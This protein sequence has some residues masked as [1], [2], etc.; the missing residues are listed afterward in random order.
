MPMF[1]GKDI[2]SVITLLENRRVT[3]YHACH[4]VD[5]ESYFKLGGIPS[6][7]LL[8]AENLS[9]TS[10]LMDE[11]SPEDW[12][13]NKVPFQLIDFG[14]RFARDP[15]NLPN[16]YGPILLEIDPAALKE[17]KKVAVCLR[18]GNPEDYR[19]NAVSILDFE[20]TEHI[21][22]YT[23]DAPFPEKTYFKTPAEMAKHFGEKKENEL[24]PEIHCLFD[25]E[26][27]PFKYVT[28]ML[29]D[30]YRIV[31]HYLREWAFMIQQQY[32]N[33]IP[34]MQR[35]CPYDIGGKLTNTLGKLMTDASPTLDD[36]TNIENDQIRP[37]AKFLIENGLEA[38]YDQFVGSMRQ[39]TILP[40]KNQQLQVARQVNDPQKPLFSKQTRELVNKLLK[41]KVPVASI[42]RI[43]EV[44]EEDI[45]D[46][47][48]RAS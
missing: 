25:S 22:R 26:K 47:I 28:Q 4:L 39:G 27:L 43:T 46:H 7:S 33:R 31:D 15:N 13:W 8:E 19:N 14:N 48:Q 20:K 34:I 6:R 45:R 18:P 16:R 35:Y 40:V 10:L 3:L 36:L 37:W 2:P 30:N 5:L 32:H 17:A 41:E 21:F 42:A 44:S 11:T 23:L 29:V 24:I 9:Y 38:K 1:V 12:V